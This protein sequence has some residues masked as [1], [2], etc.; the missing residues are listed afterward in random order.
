VEQNVI[1]QAH[2]PSKVY[3][4]PYK[5][6]ACRMVFNWKSMILSRGW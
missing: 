4:I 6:S 5:G 2:F 3:D 1:L